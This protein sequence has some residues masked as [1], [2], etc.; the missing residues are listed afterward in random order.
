MEATQKKYKYVFAIIDAFTKFVWLY[1]TKSTS[2]EEVIDKLSKQSVIFGNPKRI[3]SDRGT[4]FTAKNFEQ[5]C[6][7]AEIQHILITTGIPR[8]NG[9]VERI[10]RIIIPML[11]KLSIKKPSEWYK[12]V[13]KVQ[14]YINST[15]SRSTGHSP[16]KIL[17]GIEM[18]T[19]KQTALAEIGEII[20]KEYIEMFEKNRNDLRLTAM[21][22][23]KKIQEEN[24]K[25]FNSGRKEPITYKKDDVVAIR[26]TQHIQEKLK[27]NFLGPYKVVYQGKNNRY[28][29][30]KVGQ[31]EGP[32]KTTTAADCMKNWSEELLRDE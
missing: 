8:S 12:H 2:C 6:K 24:R 27:T 13:D 7:E 14:Q 10:N 11:C 28:G 15:T 1:P 25:N 3:I 19:N 23:L 4:A 32:N 5:Y 30:E 26:R 9:Q 21:E 22:N 31:H 17:T 20:E 16:F 18:K 29:V